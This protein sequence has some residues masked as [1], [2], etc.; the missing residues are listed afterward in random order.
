MGEQ[1]LTDRQTSVLAEL[2]AS[3][4]RQSILIVGHATDGSDLIVAVDVNTAPFERVE[5]GLPALATE[6]IYL[7][8][9][10]TYPWLPPQAHVDHHRWDG[11]PHVLQGT[12]LACTSTRRRNGTPS[13]DERLPPTPVGLARR[14]HRQPVRPGDGPLPTRGRC[15]TPNRW[16]PHHG[17]QPAPRNAAYGFRV[18]DIAIQS[19]AAH[20][21]DVVS[22]NPSERPADDAMHGVLVVLSEAMPRGGGHYLSDLAVAIRAQNSRKQRKQFITA[23]SRAARS[24]DRDQH[25]HVLIAVPNRHLTGEAR[26]HLIGWRLAQPRIAQALEATRRRHHPDSPHPDDEPPVEWTVVDDRRISLTTR[27]DHARPVSWFAGKAV[28]L[29]GCGALGSLIAE[30]LVRAAVSTITLRDT[31]YVTT[32]LLV[33]QNYTELDVGRPKVDALAGRL[34]AISDHITVHPERGIAQA[35]L[36]GRVDADVIIDCTVNIGVSV[37]LEQEQSAGRLTVPVV[38]VA[39]DDDS[40]SLGILTSRAETTSTR[41]TTS[42]PL[43]TKQR[44]PI[45]HST[46][47]LRSGNRRTTRRSPRPSAAPSRPSTDPRRMRAPSQP[48]QRAPPRQRSAADRPAGICSPWP[49]APRSPEAHHCAGKRAPLTHARTCAP[50]DLLRHTPTRC[51]RSRR[52][53]LRRS[54]YDA[55]SAERRGIRPGELTRAALC[56]AGWRP[57]LPNATDRR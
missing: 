42:T 43:C 53:R 40:A 13:P 41:P 38:Q 51:A 32:G 44:P 23:I 31:G 36:G 50:T 49:T 20:R 16:R 33:R 45:H 3:S 52:A 26:H 37:A 9:P 15:P 34:R 22:S 29:W 7:V 1:E 19:R 14:R 6:R 39:T 25:L 56:S 2:E 46:P 21:V 48:A 27:R 18:E 28:E 5:G 17:R 12:R 8:V 30:H 11:Y 10:A 24:L 54:A 55:M 35:V 47:S 4:S 57:W